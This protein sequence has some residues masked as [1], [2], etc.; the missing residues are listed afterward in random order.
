MGEDTVVITPCLTSAASP[1]LTC[2]TVSELAFARRT[3]EVTNS[4][5]SSHSP[6]TL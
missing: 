4:P 2:F 1:L 3:K 5:L 6:S